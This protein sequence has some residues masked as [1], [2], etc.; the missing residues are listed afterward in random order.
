MDSESKPESIKPEP[1]LDAAA[2]LATEDAIQA[3]AEPP[4]HRRYEQE[5]E[6]EEPAEDSTEAG[7]AG[8]SESSGHGREFEDEPETEPA[9]PPRLERLQ[10]ILAQAGIASR[11]HAE[12]LI[13][14]GRV[15]VNG[16]VVTTLGTKANPARDHIRVDGKLIHGAERL[17][18]FMLNKP[19]GFVTTASDPEGR[20]TVMQFFSKMSERLYPVGRLDYLSEGLLLVTNDG[21]LAN[22]LT[23]AA[24]HVEKTYLVKVSGRPTE[25]ALDHLRG[26]VAIDRE[27]AGSDKVLTAPAR[28]RQVRQ[29][30]NPWYEVVVIE[31]RNRELR[32]M[33]SEIGHFVEK[34]RRVGYG[35][36]VLSVEPGKV[37][38]LDPAEVD[39]LRK[40][41]GG[42]LKPRKIHAPATLPPEAGIP[43]GERAV[44]KKPF[45]RKP[46]PRE[47]GIPAG[48]RALPKKPFGRRPPPREEKRFERPGPVRREGRPA[49]SEDRPP[50]G[51]DRRKSLPAQGREAKPEWKP[52]RKPEWRSDRKTDRPEGAVRGER[53]QRGFSG[54]RESSGRQ[55]GEFAGRQRPDVAGRQRSDPSGRQR[56]EFA[57]RQR[58]DVAG[59]QRPDVAGRER[60]ERREPGS[61]DRPRKPT[62]SFE[63]GSGRGFSRH[64][65]DREKRPGPRLV[66]RGGKSFGQRA[67]S[68]RESPP[69][70]GFRPREGSGVPPT[71]ASRSGNRGNAAAPKRGGSSGS[72]SAF[73]KA[74][75]SRPGK[76]RGPQRPNR[77]GGPKGGKPR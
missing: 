4:A 24:S 40:T 20:P 19:K 61:G 25:A 12:E 22:K 56:G 16:Q 70:E 39:A 5:P 54:S 43:A 49:R 72:R 38:E 71:G 13:T 41:A 34:I 23:R 15:Q 69:R 64:E 53:Q 3:D 11:R 32:K 18:Y 55:R 50:Q 21:E 36:L 6:P 58:P 27:G 47:A 73:G 57:G 63:G 46:P 62:G 35:P 31:G 33:F 14:G 29:G 68:G 66:G 8:D 28:I 76:G 17:R 51:G 60:R 75:G 7:S 37:R 52:S 48:E 45:G 2:D 42:K 10:K 74:H 30:E 1:E 9:P 77:Q 67:A 59:R 26:G 44:P 65:G